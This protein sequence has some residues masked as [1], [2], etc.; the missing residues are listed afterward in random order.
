MGSKSIPPN[1]RCKLFAIS[2]VGSSLHVERSKAQHST[3][4]HNAHLA[5]G[6]G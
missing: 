3:A 6:Q 5:T 4:Q 1:S 2:R